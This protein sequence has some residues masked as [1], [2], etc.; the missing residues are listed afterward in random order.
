MTNLTM[1][2]GRSWKRCRPTRSSPARSTQCSLNRVTPSYASCGG[3]ASSWPF[4]RRKPDAASPRSTPASATSPAPRR[5]GHRPSWKGAGKSA[6]RWWSALGLVRLDDTSS[7]LRPV[8]GRTGT[9][10]AGQ[11]AGR[12]RSKIP[13]PF[14]PFA[15]TGCARR[16]PARTGVLR[17]AKRRGLHR[18]VRRPNWP[19]DIKMGGSERDR[20]GVGQESLSMSS[21]CSLWS[22]R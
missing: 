5:A 1:P 17:E 22:S 2:G 12:D 21:R 15:P 7:I 19:R 16:A 10:R 18:I 6:G 20:E 4:R 3:A 9:P 13:G 11:A 8:A 14:R